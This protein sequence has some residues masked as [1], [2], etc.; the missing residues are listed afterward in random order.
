M[1]E[2][3]L[4]A[5]VMRII[6]D[7]AVVQGFR[8][9][10]TVF[11][12]VGCLSHV[13]PE[14]MRFAFNAQRPG[15]LAAEARLE[16]IATAGRAWCLE[17]SESVPLSRRG[18][19]CPQCDVYKLTVIA[20]QDDHHH[21][22]HF[23]EDLAHAKMHALGIPHDHHALD[24]G[25]GAAGVS[26]PGLDQARIVKIEQDVLGHNDRLAAINRARFRQRDLLAPLC[27]PGGDVAA[28]EP[29]R[30]GAA[31]LYELGRG[32]EISV[33]WRNQ[34]A[35]PL[36]GKVIA[37]KVNC[38]PTSSAGRLFDAACGLLGVH[39]VTTFEGA[40]S[41]GVGGVGDGDQRVAGRVGGAPRCHPWCE[42]VPRHVERGGG[43]VGGMAGSRACVDRRALGRVFL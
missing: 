9:V 15:T 28:R 34:A 18:D 11:L 5:G 30:M 38:P 6:E 36:L 17:C 29:W 25:A 40:G 22:D 31:A 13:D 32:D 19:P 37:R 14:L 2:M 3:A 16:I 20:G 35:A 8:K 24:Y 23:P 10:K 26:V 7:Q 12:E 43:A 21:H 42:P 4:V 1:H 39:P 27:Q 41:H 33:R